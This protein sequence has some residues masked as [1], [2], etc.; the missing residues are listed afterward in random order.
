M[1]ESLNVESAL[2][3]CIYVSDVRVERACNCTPRCECAGG[4]QTCRGVER[5]G[6]KGHRFSNSI[7]PSLHVRNRSSSAGSLTN[8][9]KAE[10][11]LQND[12]CRSDS[13]YAWLLVYSFDV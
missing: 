1:E 5:E 10:P 11:W 4:I 6:R 9:V 12:K 2:R 13:Q 7:S 3:G 8:A